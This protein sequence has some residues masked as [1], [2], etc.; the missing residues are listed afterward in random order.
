MRVLLLFFSGT[1]HTERC[2]KAIKEAFIK[3]GH[4]VES[5]RYQAGVTPAYDI[6]DFD[7]VGLGYPIHAFNLPQA[8]H[9]FIKALPKV[10]KPYFIFKVSGEPFH[11][12]DA[13]SYHSYKVLR[14]KGYELIAEK[15]FIMPYNIIFR[16]KDELAKQMGLYLSPLAEAFVLGILNN[17]PET[18]K[19]KFSKKV[20]SFFFRIEWI[21]PKLN[22]PFIHVKK[23]KCIH[24]NKCIKDCPMN[25][26]SLTE[27]GKFK[28]HA[29][30]C[31][32]CMRCAMDCPSDAITFGFMNPWKVN[33]PYPFEKLAKDESIDPHFVKEGR[34]GYFKKFLPYF[35]KADALLKE[36]DIPNPLD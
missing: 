23:K 33:G 1:G 8:F 15:H 21:A 6:N 11:L 12:N 18:I 20:V 35:K 3:H 17:K 25:A 2:A 32:M 7:M 26:I 16:Y 4:E 27:K 5:Y 13:S 24:C 36:Y 30:K 22:A 19:Y 9:R 31:A 28:F 10:N 14:K 34:K 29:S